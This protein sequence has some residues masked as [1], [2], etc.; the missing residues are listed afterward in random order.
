M[1]PLRD[2]KLREHVAERTRHA[3]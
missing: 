2:R 1:T 3:Q